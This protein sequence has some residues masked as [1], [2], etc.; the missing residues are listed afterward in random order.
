MLKL[1]NRIHMAITCVQGFIIGMMVMSCTHSVDGICVD[2]AAL[3]QSSSMH[4]KQAKVAREVS[5]FRTAI[6]QADSAL[7]RAQEC[8]D[9]IAIVQAYNELGT[10]FRRMGRMEKALRFHYEALRYAEPCCDTCF[11]ARKNIVVS[12]NGLGNAYLTLGETDMAARFFRRALAGEAALGSEL[13]QAINYANLG[14]IYEQNGEL[15]SAQ[16]YYEQSMRLNEQ[17]GS[18]LGIGLCHVYFGQVEERRGHYAAAI[19]EYEQ[20]DE[21]FCEQGDLWH[22]VEPTMALAGLYLKMGK[23]GKAK[24]YVDTSI[25]TAEKIH[26]LEHL[27]EAYMLRAQ[28]D[29]QMG[30]PAA[31]L[32][33]YKVAMAY[34]DSLH[35]P[36]STTEIREICLD[37]EQMKH[38]RI[39]KAL[40]H[41]QEQEERQEK[42]NHRLVIWISLLLLLVGVY[43]LYILR[44][45]LTLWVSHLLMKQHPTEHSSLTEA[46]SLWLSEIQRFILE[47][48]PDGNVTTEMVAEHVRMSVPTLQSRI[49]VLTGDTLGH[50]ILQTRLEHA[51]QL[52]E[53]KHLPAHEV[54][55]RCGFFNHSYFGRVYRKYFGTTPG[56]SR[57]GG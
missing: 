57:R 8:G 46:D 30:Q 1:R 34:N 9:T 31:A 2:K 56:E 4:R 20:A 13:G 23:N 10:D 36:Q 43:M 54:A 15:D 55:E 19:A 47:R 44:N 12:C 40:H 48:M 14:A 3:L 41:A 24:T 49:R 52:L 53:E 16:L 29:E 37:Y 26:S 38:D 51:K 11:Q 5:D 39:I 7:L 21:E 45:R 6:M 22:C 50:L 42:R 17:I 18:C 27:K 32:R 35:G 33:D 28:Y 25:E